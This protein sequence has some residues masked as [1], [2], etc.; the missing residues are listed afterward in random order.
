MVF[1]LT[2]SIFA[3]LLDSHTRTYN[4]FKAVGLPRRTVQFYDAAAVPH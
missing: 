1:I 3:D 2:E 4:I